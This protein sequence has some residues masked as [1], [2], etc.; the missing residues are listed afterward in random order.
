MSFSLARILL[1]K[2]VIILSRHLI[3]VL[4]SL[5]SPTSRD[6]STSF[7]MFLDHNVLIRTRI[8]P[9]WE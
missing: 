5:L 7:I 4:E 6:E 9:R 1:T 3:I 2:V 8:F